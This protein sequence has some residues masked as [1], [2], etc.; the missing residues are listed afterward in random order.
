MINIRK[1]LYTHNNKEYSILLDYDIQLKQQTVF[2]FSNF[3]GFSVYIYIYAP[4]T[5]YVKISTAI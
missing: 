3:N 4:L 5:F 1:A 2:R